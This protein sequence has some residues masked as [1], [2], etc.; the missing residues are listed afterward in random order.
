VT[1]FLDKAAD[2]A[3]G[4]VRATGHVMAW[5]GFALV[6]V[7]AGN[8]LFRYLLGL[9]SVGMQEV[10]WHLMAV[11]ALFG[12]SYGLAEGGEVRVDALYELFGPRGRASIDLL[13]ALL[14]TAIALIVLRLSLAYVAQSYAIDEGSPDPGGLGNRWA[15]KAAI[16]VA[17]GFLALQGGAMALRATAR[18]ID[19]RDPAEAR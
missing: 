17:F 1:A 3:E 15:L 19:G 8:V 7:V 18:L 5:T 4:V 16:P 9:S 14:K 11:G 6:L 2:G 10:E 12:M 13:T